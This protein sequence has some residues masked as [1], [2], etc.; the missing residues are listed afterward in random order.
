MPGLAHSHGNRGGGWLPKER[1]KPTRLR[2]RG[3]GGPY[4]GR[5]VPVDVEHPDDEPPSFSI[6]GGQYRAAK[7]N[8][9]WVYLWVPPRQGGDAA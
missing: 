1:R 2:V 8:A 7:G 6:S 5:H 9:G 3:I 4:G